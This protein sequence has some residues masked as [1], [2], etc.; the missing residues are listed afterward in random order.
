MMLLQM[1]QSG[2]IREKVSEAKIKQMLEQCAEMDSQ[3]KVTTLRTAAA[4]D[5]YALDGEDEEDPMAKA[6]AMGARNPNDSDS[7][8]Y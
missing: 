5:A 3:V 2:K 1:A 6:M 4:S 7:D 8:D